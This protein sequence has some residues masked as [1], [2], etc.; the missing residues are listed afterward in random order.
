MET[1]LHNLI[2][3]QIA[4]V[5]TLLVS[6]RIGLYF[7]DRM[8]FVNVDADLSCEPDGMFVSH[9][10]RKAGRVSWQKGAASLEVIG[11]PEMVLEVVS[12]HSV[13][14]DTVVLRELYHAAGIAEYWL[15]NPLSGRL[16]LEILRRTAKGYVLGR[17][18]GGWVKSSVFGKS[19]R[20]MPEKIGSELPECKLLVR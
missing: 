4:A 19:F 5:L 8:R 3:G 16:S 9:E 2:K 17:R 15:V 7:G 20:L 13:Q 6:G 12:S 1:L 18:A 10:A 14:K 11:S